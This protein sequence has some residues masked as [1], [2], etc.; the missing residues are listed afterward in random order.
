MRAAPARVGPPVRVARGPRRAAGRR[1][2][3]GVRV[4][5]RNRILFRREVDESDDGAESI[6]LALGD[7]RSEHVRGVLKLAAGDSLRVGVVNGSPATAVVSTM[8]ATSMTLTWRPGVETDDGDTARRSLTAPLVDVDLLLAMPRPKVMTRLWA[9]LASIGVRNVYLTNAS[10]VE[11]YYWDS[12]ALDEAK[13]I[14]ELTR[15]M[16]QSGDVRMPGVCVVRR[17]PAAVD[18]VREMTGAPRRDGGQEP[19]GRG[20]REGGGNGGGMPREGS[21]FWLVKPPPAD[22]N[23]DDAEVVMLTA[24]PGAAATVGDAFGDLSSSSSSS[25]SGRPRR[26]RAV[27][28]VGPEGGWTDFE[29]RSLLDAGF[30]EVA[31]GRRT[32]ATDVACVALVAAVRERTSSW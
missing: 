16:E 25:S 8:D 23:D 2:I 31:L 32:F 9:P 29:R 4:E 1:S 18:A 24:H 6:T 30:V 10:R 12:T 11:R 27:V 21:A 7:S 22:E 13:V 15:G 14:A 28:A 26:T 5:C 19:R 20:G 3:R 17:F